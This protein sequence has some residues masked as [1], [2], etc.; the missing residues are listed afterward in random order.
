[1]KVNI[2]Y[3]EEIIMKNE[4]K[5]KIKE[6][7]VKHK[8]KVVC[9]TGMIIGGVIVGS[10]IKSKPGEIHE[11]EVLPD[12][13][14]EWQQHCFTNDLLCKNGLPCFADKSTMTL[15]SDAMADG[16]TKHDFEKN[17]F[18]IIERA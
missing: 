7:Y 10:V 9:F 4:T 3:K 17:G 16:F 15:Y 12:W 2:F 8:M 5:Q 11:F 1:M 14:K 18:T 6:F 13:A